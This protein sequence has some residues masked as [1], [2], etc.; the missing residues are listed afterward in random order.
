MKVKVTSNE[1]IRFLQ[2]ANEIDQ[3]L[4]WLGQVTWLFDHWID[5]TDSYVSLSLPELTARHAP[6]PMKIFGLPT[7]LSIRAFPNRTIL[8]RYIDSISWMAVGVTGGERTR[9]FSIA[10]WGDAK[11]TLEQVKRRLRVENLISSLIPMIFIFS[12]FVTLALTLD[13]WFA[14]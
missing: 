5:F 13:L 12:L 10:R 7:W 3:E 2:A 14:L 1:F 11:L 9:Y 4:Q 6:L 8:N